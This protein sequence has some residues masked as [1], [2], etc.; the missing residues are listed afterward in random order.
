MQPVTFDQ[1]LAADAARR[2]QDGST[3]WLRDDAELA[4]MQAEHAAAEQAQA[5][6]AVL[7]EIQDRA[8]GLAREWGYDDARSA[9]TYLGDPNPRFAAEALAVRDYRSAL[10][11]YADANR[12]ATDP[13]AFLAGLPA[14]PARP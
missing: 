1:F 11:S 12:N 7:S 6:A 3:Y 5:L 4:A 9:C 14:A 2:H 13:A 8:D 10:W